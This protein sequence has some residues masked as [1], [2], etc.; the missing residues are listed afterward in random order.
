MGTGSRP[1]VGVGMRMGTGTRCPLS[2]AAAEAR[3]GVPSRN[4]VRGH[5]RATRARNRQLRGFS[6]FYFFPFFPPSPSLDSERSCGARGSLAGPV[7]AAGGGGQ[8]RTQSPPLKKAWKLLFLKVF[9]LRVLDFIFLSVWFEFF[10]KIFS[11]GFLK[12]LP[13]K[14]PV[15]RPSAGAEAAAGAGAAH[16]VTPC[17]P[18]PSAHA[19]GLLLTRC[20]LPMNPRNC[21]A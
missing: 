18:N 3:P 20:W 8:S 9:L 1:G 15:G 2:P 6:A 10:K 19:E 16:A 4:S 13:S 11:C 14:K 12:F 21:F 7:R 17:F 5:L